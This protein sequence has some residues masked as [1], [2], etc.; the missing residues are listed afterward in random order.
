M[1]GARHW[2]RDGGNGCHVGREVPAA[3]ELAIGRRDDTLT[4]QA[5]NDAEFDLLQ[6]SPPLVGGMT[7]M[8][9]VVMHTMVGL[10]WSPP[11]VGG[12]TEA[13]AAGAEYPM[14]LQWTRR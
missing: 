14:A 12:M 8:M 6:W 11:L 2:S 3:M 13:V 5:L 4:Y 10:Q 1:V 7:A 9:G